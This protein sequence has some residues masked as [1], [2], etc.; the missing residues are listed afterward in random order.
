MPVFDSSQTMMAGSAAQSTGIDIGT[1][2][3]GKSLL[4]D[5]SSSEHL[6]RTPAGAGNR[7]TFTFS[8][9]LKICKN[10]DST[11]FTVFSGG[12]TLSGEDGEF[13]VKFDNGGI[14]GQ[15]QIQTGPTV[16]L[17]TTQCFRDP[18]AWGHLV[19]AVDTTNSIAD[20]R[21]R[22]Y[23]N[24]YEITDFDTRNNPALNQ[25][26]AVNNTVEHNIGNY[27][28]I[29]SQYY[30]GYIAGVTFVDGEQLEASAFGH[31][32]V[33]TGAWVMEDIPEDETLATGG[34]LVTHAGQYRVH[35]FTSN[36]TFTVSN[37]GLVEYLVVGGGGGGGGNYGGGGG[38]GGFQT[39]FLNIPKDSYSITIG[40]GGDGGIA[41][42]PTSGDNGDAGANSVFH[43][44]T[45]LGGGYG[46]ALDADSGAGG[47]G[48]SGG[49]SRYGSASGSATPFH[50][51]VQG[52]A[53]GTGSTSASNY[54]SGGGGGASAVGTGGSGS[55]GGVGGAGT[56]STISGAAV[57]Y[58]GGGGGGV[59]HG[60]TAGAG[61]SGGG[62]AAGTPVDSGTTG[63]TGTA[64]TVNT[65]GGGG[66]GS[67]GSNG[68]VGGAGGSGVVYIRYFNRTAT[69]TVSGGTVT[70]DGDYKVHKFTANGTLTVSAG[71]G[72]EYLV[73]AG[74]GAGG[75]VD[76]GGRNG[77]GGGGAGGFRTGY[78]EVAA[79]SIS[80]TVGDGGAAN[81]NSNMSG[82]NGGNSVF[83][84]ITSV[85][86][87]GGGG[88]T[89]DTKALYDGA[90][91]GSGGGA[92][93]YS[94][95]GDG[96]DPV[97]G[98]GFAGGDSSG[99]GGAGGGGAGAVGAGN[100]SS[101]GGAGGAGL[102]SSIT[103]ASVTYAGGGGG[104]DYALGGGGGAGGSGGGGAGIGTGR[105]PNA[106]TVNTG[107]GGGAIAHGGN[108]DEPQVAL[109]GVG[110]SGIVIV[111]VFTPTTFD[112]GTNG[113]YLPFDNSGGI[114]RGGETEFTLPVAGTLTRTNAGN[115][116]S[117]AYFNRV[118]TGN[119]SFQWTCH[120]SN[121][122]ASG[123]SMR[124]GIVP[125]TA[126]GSWVH[127]NGTGS[128]ATNHHVLFGA[129]NLGQCTT[130]AGADD[131]HSAVG[132]ISGTF[133]LTRE[134]GDTI[135][136][137]HDSGSGFAL[138]HTFSVTSSADMVFFYGSG[139]KDNTNSIE[140]F[141]INDD[142][143]GNSG[144]FYTASPGNDS[145]GK[146]NDWHLI[147]G[148]K[149]MPDTP[150]N[151]F[152]TFNA[153]AFNSLT[154]SN[155][156]LK[157]TAGGGGQETTGT[158]MPRTGKWYFELLLQNL[159]SGYEQFGVT[160][161]TTKMGSTYLEG[162]NYRNDGL[163]YV[164]GTGTASYGATW[165]TGDVMAAAV[166]LDANT[167]IFYKNN[168]SQ[169]SLSFTAGHDMTPMIRMGASGNIDV[170]NFGQDSS[171]DGVKAKQNNADEN[172]YGDFYYSPPSGY[173]ALC[174][175][176]LPEI[177]IGQEEDKRAGDYFSSVLYTGDGAQT[178]TI[179]GIG[180]QPDLVWQKIRS[181][182]AQ[183]FGAWDSIR[184]FA[185][186]KAYDIGSA[187]AEGTWNGANSSDY[188]DITSVGAGTVG[189][190]D[191]ATATTGGYI[192]YAT[193][194]YILYNWLAGNATLGT[195][196][197]TQG[198]IA[199][200]C[201][202]NT[203]AGFSIVSYTGTGSAG[204]IGHGLSKAPD[205]I[206]VK[207]EHNHKGQTFFI[208]LWTLL[209]QKIIKWI[210][211]IP[212]LDMMEM[213]IGMIRPQ[214]QQYFQ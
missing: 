70:T 134:G 100:S 157:A 118:L 130:Q 102:A 145:S 183:F 60:G 139:E 172:G 38:A 22:V 125:A 194:E 147:E 198:T 79:G 13:N 143:N 109:G 175:K 155:G 34:N 138:D 166:D 56:T 185:S 76:T 19:V 26:F 142:G 92:S 27:G 95:A 9:W 116:D 10:F 141:V 86:G 73:V 195:G 129:G 85:G 205:M 159:A 112:F 51:E 6:T 197:F 94:S 25:D 3:D 75:G 35:K 80:I 88:A 167:I 103:G 119:F 200:T 203:D 2:T 120:S 20:N 87:G 171:F 65:G 127:T 77:T 108:Y 135:K 82:G 106:G 69:A 66:G 44:I 97:A 101:S 4:L 196:D 117:S 98:Q 115:D 156:N 63:S 46:G 50:S 104:A 190:N 168:A 21:I 187:T 177:E 186:G 206:I 43:T 64:G 163:K 148:G 136:F 121:S 14:D 114:E 28:R 32:S 7:K 30:D 123:D 45:A 61:G 83:S 207:I 133:K 5:S 84:T 58:A 124:I 59:Y 132:S 151:N 74:G 181:G 152:A 154:L 150:V 89:V 41:I 214:H 39:G 54:G 71:G 40:E 209:L 158:M 78:L 53:G 182:T 161:C 1:Y 202:R 81:T 160:R 140:N 174:T 12:T 178:R 122:H 170:A 164:E 37:P 113:F 16:L 8:A 199:S 188:G 110:G 15:L 29:D 99:T 191:G 57:T 18:N 17:E 212:M 189:L 96:G 31:P 107:G 48:A 204:T 62:G 153:L 184:T 90:D 208:V 213:L 128:A 146:N 67:A 68:G 11:G 131:S 36:G 55:A 165:T 91:G 173:L 192:N 169:G 211:I 111:R 144:N 42:A 33:D 72:V 105:T 210:W 180:F 193:R 49:G 23:W 137:Y 176:N 149:Q 162:V 52:F 47:P 179:S 126:R 201:S 24:G 93:N